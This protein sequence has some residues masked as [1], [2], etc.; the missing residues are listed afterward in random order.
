VN[1]L[2]ALLPA[3]DSSSASKVNCAIGRFVLSDGKLSEK[4]I[5]IDTTRMRVAGK[6]EADFK[7][8][9]I[10]LYVQPHAKTPQI[11][12]FPLPI[13]LSGKFTDFHVGVRPSDVLGTVVQ[14]ATSAVWVP[15]E[16]LFGKQPPSDGRDVCGFEFQ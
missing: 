11:L 6:G 12:S 15:I 4:T 8:E 5:L 2:T 16:T 3:V 1:V 10:H 13:E 9:D 7:G 14:F